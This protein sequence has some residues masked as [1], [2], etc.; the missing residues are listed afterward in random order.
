LHVK[1]I[2][3][4]A[5]V[6]ILTNLEEMIVLVTAQAAEEVEEVEGVEEEGEEAEPQV[7]EKGKKEEDE[8]Y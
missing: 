5:R 2:Q 7:I 4:P 3:V 6:E 8:E 1:D